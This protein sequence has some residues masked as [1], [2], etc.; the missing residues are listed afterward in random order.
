MREREREGWFDYARWWDLWSAGEFPFVF[1]VL[2]SAQM[3]ELANPF[4]VNP[5]DS[6]RPG[7]VGKSRGSE[8]EF[9]GMCYFV[10]RGGI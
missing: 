2:V 6:N 5:E 4:W 3:W 7:T 10:E 8:G 9:A 1:S